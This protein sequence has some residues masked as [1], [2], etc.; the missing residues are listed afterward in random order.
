VSI[1]Y[2][3]LIYSFIIIT[4]I[5]LGI[6]GIFFYNQR[7][8]H[9]E[10]IEKNISSI[11]KELKEISFE[12]IVLNND[13][14]LNQYIKTI[15][16]LYPEI[17]EISI[18]NKDGVIVGHSNINLWGK[19]YKMD[20]KISKEKVIKTDEFREYLIPLFSGKKVIG[21]IDIKFSKK[22][23]DKIYSEK[24]K[25]L[26]KRVKIFFLISA[27]I[28]FIFSILLANIVTSPIKVIVGGIKQFGEGKWVEVKLNRKDEL[29]W[30]AKE[31]NK[32]VN[33]LKELDELKDDFLSGVTH[34]LRSPLAAIRT[35][36]NL[37]K[38]EKIYNPEH[39]RWIE[40]NSKRLSRFVDD[41]L[42]M[43]KIEKG[44]LEIIKQE[45]NVEK[46]V[47]EVVEFFRPYALEKKVK[48]N[49]EI[50]TKE[51]T[52]F[53][54]PDRIHQVLVNLISNAVKFTPSD[55]AIFVKVIDNEKEF[56]FK[57]EDEGVGIPEDE[58]RNIFDKFYQV[59]RTDIRAK[60][61]GLGL[62]ICKGIVA[63]HGG[64]I[65]VESELG[66]G[67]KFYFTIPKKVR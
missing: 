7:K 23:L 39:I 32:M 40:D 64:R 28:G 11:V 56:I 16:K 31:F 9:K 59:R 43:S 57:V 26:K 29:G 35:Y 51:K 49:M 38:E 12:G 4:T 22:V 2:K 60:G 27:L 33:K 36:I 19:R 58:L 3:F 15:I 52:I 42:D 20:I 13:L 67:T 65:W 44:K 46:I 63:K 1:K 6:S 53:A 18:M 45:E 48:L 34:E 55:R 47:R 41:L 5:I 14:L 50:K 10:I 24:L 17:N 54:D 37:I 61:T 21:Y 66:K 8:S 25:S 30:L 62:A